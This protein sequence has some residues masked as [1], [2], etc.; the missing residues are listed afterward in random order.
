M[1]PIPSIF[2][3]K[4]GLRSVLF[5]AS[6]CVAFAP[7]VAVG[8][9]SSFCAPA[10]PYSQVSR[11][12]IYGVA[13]DLFREGHYRAAAR[14]YYQTFVCD[15]DPLYFGVNPVVD[16]A[17]VRKPFEAALQAAANGSFATAVRALQVV[18]K[19]LSDF[20]EAR[21]LTGIFQWSEG[22]RVEA[23]STWK[24]VLTSGYFT[25]PPETTGSPAPF[26]AAREMLSWSANKLKR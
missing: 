23:R 25:V 17:D 10:I 22:R 8:S 26:Q 16:D 20:A 12:S 18:T 24:K 11:H 9:A 2:T 6:L 5:C 15:G 1:R 13:D 21:F 3:N 14:A 19:Q 4:A 7:A